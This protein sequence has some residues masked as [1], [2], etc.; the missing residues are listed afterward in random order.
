MFNNHIGIGLEVSKVV[1]CNQQ[2]EK[3]LEN[4]KTEKLHTFQKRFDDAIKEL[5]KFF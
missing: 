1:D 4:T 2:E 3:L 5:N